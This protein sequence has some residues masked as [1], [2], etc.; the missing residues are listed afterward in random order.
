MSHWPNPFENVMRIGQNIVP[1]L[2]MCIDSTAAGAATTVKQQHQ[3]QEQPV[4]G[5]GRVD[6]WRDR[7][8]GLEEERGRG[9]QQRQRKRGGVN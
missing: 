5:G 3:L 1:F 6:S 9:T 2:C 4:E 7:A 8:R